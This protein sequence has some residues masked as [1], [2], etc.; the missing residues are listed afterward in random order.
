MKR[1][2]SF[3][4]VVGLIGAA[5]YGIYHF[6]GARGD[7]LKKKVLK[8]I[9]NW[10]GESEVARAEIDRGIKGMDEAVDTLTNARIKAQVQYEML[11]K[12][13]KGNKKKIE[14]SKTALINLRNDLKKFDSDPTFTVSYGGKTYSKK[15]ELDKMANKVIDHHETL[16]AQT[17]AQEKRLST[18]ETSMTTLRAREDEAKT[19]RKELKEKLKDLDS[20]IALAKAQKEAAQALNESDKSFGESVESIE[21]KIRTLDLSTEAA[22]RKEEEKWKEITAKTEVEDAKQIIKDSKSTVSKIDAL[23]GSK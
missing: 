19:K 7:V 12:E 20:K 8:K 13:I 17:E 9:D 4:V 5:G 21:E 18:Y 15:D 23:L 14:E 16:V 10:L 1:L 11:D 2:V 22:V 3:V 6:A